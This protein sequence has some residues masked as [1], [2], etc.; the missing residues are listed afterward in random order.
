MRLISVPLFA[1]LIATESLAA[2]PDAAEPKAEPV[3]TKV[4]HRAKVKVKVKPEAKPEA[5][6]D[7]KPEAKTDS[8]PAPAPVKEALCEVHV[9][10]DNVRKSG[11]QYR[12]QIC[13]TVFKGK[14][15]FPDKSQLAFTNHCVPVQ[16]SPTVSFTLKELPCNQD[17]GVALLHDENMNGHLD[18]NMAIPK[19]GIGMSKNPS[20]VRVNSPPYDDVKFMVQEPHSSQEIR[21]HYF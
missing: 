17:Y 10:V 15:G 18:K 5:T 14:D 19:E 2:E 4:R 8:L 1:L 11:D 3:V 7:V 20:F 12:G 6:S 21:I 16:Q 13:Y 9:T